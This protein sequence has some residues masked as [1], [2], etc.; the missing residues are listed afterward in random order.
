MQFAETWPRSRVGQKET[1]L[2]TWV[3]LPQDTHDAY[4]EMMRPEGCWDSPELPSSE[5]QS[6]NLLLL[7][8]PMV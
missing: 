2:S 1:Q 7:V 8:T 6:S 5:V 4:L 3:G